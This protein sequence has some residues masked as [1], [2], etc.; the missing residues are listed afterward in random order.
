MQIIK[1]NFLLLFMCITIKY[2]NTQNNT[3]YQLNIQQALEIA[4]AN[5]IL[6]KNALLD[7]ATAKQQINEIIASGLPQINGQVQFLHNP[8]VATMAL[9][10]FI[11]PAVYGNLVAY[12]L[13]D[14]K[15]PNT[16]P[17][18]S[19]ILP[20]Q[21]GV[22]NSLMA[23]VSASQL[24]FDGGFLM[25]V[26]ASKEFAHLSELNAQQSEQQLILD[27]K[28]SYYGVQLLQSTLITINGNVEMLQ[29]TSNEINA[30][31]QVGFAERIDA[32]RIKL[33]LSNIQVQK[34]KVQDQL[35]IAKQYL[36]LTLGIEP[37]DSIVLTD[38]LDKFKPEEI[39]PNLNETGIRIEQKIIESQKQL[40]NL[41]KMRWQYGYAPSLVA[42]GSYQQN[43]FGNSIGDVGKQWFEGITLGATLS[44]PIFDGLRKHAQIQKTKINN[45]KIDNG[46]SIL[47][48]SIEIERFNARSKYLR[49]KEQ[50]YVQ[51]DNAKLAEE[52]YKRANLRY[53]E[54]LGSSLE[55]TTAQTDLL[56]AQNNKLNAMYE[57]LVAEAELK[58]AIGN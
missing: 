3:I 17:P 35:A 6:Y 55:I 46:K 37:T 48:K 26:R 58:K 28:K 41:D 43:T 15:N 24:L 47:Q 11:S 36:K 5:N 52:I 27:V 57:L 16:P 50:Y 38:N 12:G 32:D 34:N 7:K 53:K 20:A 54:G 9:P 31:Y 25:G 10:D 22:K 49:A 21:F 23:S 29:K 33:A 8:V 30:T 13:V 42:F 1:N 2:A 19:R 56:N 45:K 40:N 18:P 39:S 44:I 14:P 51:A 4:K